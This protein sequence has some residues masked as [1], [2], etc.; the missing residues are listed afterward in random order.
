[1]ARMFS[2][3]RL[4]FPAWNGEWIK[5]RN[6]SFARGS[7]SRS[8]LLQWP[9]PARIVFTNTILAGVGHCNN[10]ERLDQP[11]ANETFRCFIHAPFHAGKRSRRIENI[12]AIVQVQHGIAF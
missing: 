1:M 9:T 2:M 5:Q 4:R 10:D 8:S 3:R 6:V 7:S 11:L 12:L